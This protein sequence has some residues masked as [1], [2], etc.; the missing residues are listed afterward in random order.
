MDHD[1]LVERETTNEIIGAF[2]DVYNKLGFGFLEHVYCA[3]LERE[4][5]KRGKNVARQFL[6]QL[7]Y[8]GEALST[9]RL[10]FIVDERV[11][12]EV[13]STATLPPIAQ[14]QTLNYL[15]A[16]T[17]EVA[18]LLHFGPEP[19]FHRLVHTRK[20]FRKVHP[21]GAIGPDGVKQG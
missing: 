14:R 3:A 11:V 10:D 15:R 17:L 6:V 20:A 5:L 12:V 1:D 16:S 7:F 4:L 2:Y 9:Q 13:K 21:T 8:D 18:L 19:R